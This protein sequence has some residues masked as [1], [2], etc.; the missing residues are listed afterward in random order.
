MTEVYVCRSLGEFRKWYVECIIGREPR[1]TYSH[2]LLIDMH[3]FYSA[4]LAS[5]LAQNSVAFAHQG[6]TVPF[7]SV[8]EYWCSCRTR[9]DL[10]EQAI[11]RLRRAERE[12]SYEMLEQWW[13]EHQEL[14]EEVFV[15]DGLTR[16][17]AASLGEHKIEDR[18]GNFAPVSDSIFLLH[19]DMTKEIRRAMLRHQLGAAASCFMKL[20]RIRL[21]SQKLADTLLGWV[22]VSSDHPLSY[23]HCEE[24]ALEARDDLAGIHDRRM[25][26]TL[27]QLAS[28]AQLSGLQR[29]VT[30]KCMLPQAN[31]E[32]FTAVV[33]LLGK[34]AFDDR[35]VLLDRS[36]MLGLLTKESADVKPSGPHFNLNIHFVAGQV[37][38]WSGVPGLPS[39]DR[40]YG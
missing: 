12:K 28:H 22:A 25:R 34:H 16:L 35:G 5:V 10:W 37:G 29:L 32:V 21:T 8:A 39:S 4:I 31:Y 33:A 26:T 7:N 14:L 15:T 11:I 1:G 38:A 19:H 13:G 6:A 30:T 9:L 20:N 24:T 27:M 2:P 18:D 17:V 3:S 40:W 36:A 23:V